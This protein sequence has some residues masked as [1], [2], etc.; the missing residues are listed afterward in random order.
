[1]ISGLAGKLLGGRAG[2]A[3]NLLETFSKVGFNPEQVEAFLPKALEWIKSQL[4]PELLEKLLA[5]VPA[6]AKLAGPQA[7]PGA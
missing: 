7:E 5:S 2:G 3:V 6:L 4:P 1:M